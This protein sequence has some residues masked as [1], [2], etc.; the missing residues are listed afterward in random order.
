[1]A[2]SESELNGEGSVEAADLAGTGGS[3]LIGASDSNGFGSE[4]TGA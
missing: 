2:M 4:L 3:A 1:M